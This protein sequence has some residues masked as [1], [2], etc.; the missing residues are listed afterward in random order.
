MT[1]FFLGVIAL[2]VVVMAAIQVTVVVFAARAVRRLDR[3][4]DRLE[5]DIQPVLAS[6]QAVAADAARATALAAA[7]IERASTW[8]EGLKGL[9][10]T[11]RDMKA[12]Q[13]KASG[14]VED[15]ALFIG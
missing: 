10:A 6:L 4:A 7:Q 1:D 3:I 11:I 12:P 9:L 2:A 8:L 5:Q 14:S 15:D 13:A